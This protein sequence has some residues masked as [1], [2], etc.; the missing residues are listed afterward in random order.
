MESITPNP[1]QQG[2]DAQKQQA[3][4]LGA[5]ISAYG[6]EAADLVAAIQNLAAAKQATAIPPQ[7]GKSIY[8]D[9]ETIY[10]DEHAFIYR[11]GDTATKRYYLR[12]YDENNKKPFI[13]ALGT[14]DRVKA[15]STARGIYQDIKGKIE[16][17]ERLKTITTE[18][19]ISLYLEGLQKKI[20]D[21]PRLG[22]TP[23]SFRVKQYYLRNWL[24]YITHLGYKDTPIDKIKAQKTRD[25]GYWLFS[26]PKSTI[27]PTHNTP[28]STEKINNNISE[29]LRAYKQIAIRDNYI[30]KNQAPEIDKLKEQPDET[31]KR[32]IL[33][34][35][36]YDRFWRYMLYR[37]IKEKG[38]TEV[39][40]QKRIIF[41]NTIG[42]LYNTGLRPKEFLGLRLNEISINEADSKEL[43]QTHL[44]LLV[45]RENSKTGR[46][47]VVVAPIRKRVERIRAAYKALGAEHLPQDYLI[48]V[49]NSKDR[50]QYTRQALYQRLQQVL[51][52]SGL[53]EELEVEG[54]KVSLYSSR[55]AYITWRLR[56]GDT[57]IHL[58]AKAAGTSIEKIEKTYGH[59]EVE[60]QTEILTKNQGYAKSAEVSLTTQF[61]ADGIAF[62]PEINIEEERANRINYK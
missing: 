32:D 8:Q 51:T 39:E 26:K 44:K 41:Y 15:I 48:F 47:R 21:T 7:K 52:A 19:L 58:L 35:E 54:K 49:Y 53:K 16:R 20:T 60:K 2:N 40:K 18:E 12:I 37:W 10:D 4:A 46:S 9:K 27:T 25:F 61:E 50:R 23:E 38:I 3:E 13:K 36:Q 14:T 11:R 6:L 62:T 33:T 56:Y 5:L 55:H 24:E 30:S 1:N 31:H 59:I 22:V 28:R 34:I 57:P 29:V 43:Q 45:R 17:G 42:I